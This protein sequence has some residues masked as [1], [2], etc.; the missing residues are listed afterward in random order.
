MKKIGHK[1]TLKIYPFFW[2][3]NNVVLK[4]FSNV[5]IRMIII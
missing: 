5:K 2:F 3:E 4:G 1:M